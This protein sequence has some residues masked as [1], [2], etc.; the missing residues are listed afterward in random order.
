M[1]TYAQQTDPAK[2]RISSIDTTKVIPEQTTKPVTTTQT[3]EQ[4]RTQANAT[5]TTEQPKTETTTATQVD[6]AQTTQTT[7]TAD[8][9]TTSYWSTAW[10]K[11]TKNPN[12][13]PKAQR[14]WEQPS[15][16]Q[17]MDSK[18]VATSYQAGALTAT[19]LEDLRTTD[20]LKYQE[21]KLEIEKQRTLEAINMTWETFLTTQQQLFDSY[22]QKWEEIAWS[23]EWRNIRAE[24]FKQYGLDAS[25]EKIKE[26]TTQLDDLDNELRDLEDYV[27]SWDVFTDRN[28]AVNKNKELMRKRSDL[29]RARAAEIDYYKLW[30]E[31]ADAVAEDY[32]AYQAQEIDMLWKKFEMLTGMSQMEF[33]MKDKQNR[34]YLTMIDKELVKNEAEQIAYQK[35]VSDALYAGS[36]LSLY[37]EFSNED[38][39]MLSSL[40]SEQLTAFLKN[41]WEK[42]KMEQDAMYK[43]LD[44]K[45]KGAEL[46]LKQKELQAKLNENKIKNREI[47]K[48]DDWTIVLVDKETW[49]TETAYKPAWS[50]PIQFKQTDYQEIIDFC[51][52]NRWKTNIQCGE[53]VNDYRVKNTWY[54]AGMWDSY[55]TKVNA[56]KWIWQSLSPIAWGVFAFPWW[57]Y[58]HTGIV[59]KVLEDWSIEV[60]EANRDWWNGSYPEINT[61][62]ASKVKN[63][64]F[65]FPP[66][67]SEEYEVNFNDIILPE[68]ATEFTKKWFSFANKMRDAHEKLLSYKLEDIYA[69]RT[70]IWQVWQ[71]NTFN[72][73]KSTAQKDLEVLKESFIAWILRQESWAAVTDTEFSRYE[74]IYFPLPWDTKETIQKK[75]AMREEAIKQMYIAS[76][77]DKSWVRIAD[78]YDPQDFRNKLNILDKP[79]TIY[80]DPI[81]QEFADWFGNWSDIL[82]T[83]Q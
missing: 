55:E 71:E 45:F 52:N 60:L 76:W 67:K 53:L 57:D 73:M 24:V 35:T 8:V 36:V 12:Y 7:P 33:E 78:Y 69:E 61:Y 23:D 37:N 31:Q 72:V 6:T 9:N 83:I 40:S 46:D 64:V 2:A 34:D 5:T 11:L 56:I 77:V 39:A 29:V 70:G 74:K 75:Q 10:G 15:K 18:T 20:P 13:I 58:W 14:V 63:M 44:Y 49:L 42:T 43:E 47:V 1:V 28:Y 68:K 48:L 38:K 22:L 3:P 66:A 19:E 62:S 79:Q 32:K 82:N 50:S 80:N 65:S 16:A 25:N 81:D 51:V 21:A 30:L 27:S 54:K 59:T 4:I 17:Q 41:Y 26:Y